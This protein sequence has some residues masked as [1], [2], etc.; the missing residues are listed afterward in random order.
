M[1][2][3]NLELVFI[4]DKSGSMSGLEKDTI[5][6]FNSV[7][8]KQKSIEGECRVT[9][10]LFDHEY[11]LLHDRVNINDLEDM[12]EK[13]YY[14]GGMTS[15]LDA[16]GKTINNIS[17]EIKEEENFMF[18]IITDGEENSSVEYSLDKIKKLVEIKKEMGWEFIFMGANIDA[19]KTAA[20]YGI[21]EDRSSD[22]IADE[23]GVNLNYEIMGDV[24]SSYRESSKISE[25][26]KEK[27]EEDLKRK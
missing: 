24:V 1:T 11:K 23:K 13:D 18:I 3:K 8:E 15:L 4:L 9:T 5:G 26:W 14:V 25:N 21:D 22:F 6:G 20:M 27:I 12:T 10:V 19:I 17:Q 7:I 16:M 2:N